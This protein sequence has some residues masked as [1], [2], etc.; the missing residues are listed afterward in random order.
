MYAPSSENMPVIAGTSFGPP[1]VPEGHI[2]NGKW[3]SA[4]GQHGSALG[5]KA[6][7]TVT[8]AIIMA[9]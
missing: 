8:S 3:V 1:G 2:G 4:S 7:W 6:H 5:P 9:V